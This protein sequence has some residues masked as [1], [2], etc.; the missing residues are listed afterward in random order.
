VAARATPPTPAS[1]N[2]GRKWVVVVVVV[3]ALGVI[4][5]LCAS[6]AIAI[7]T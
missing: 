5:I 6:R 7:L 1:S 2:I 3:M 4:E